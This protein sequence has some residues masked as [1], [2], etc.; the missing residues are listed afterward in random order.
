MK[1]FTPGPWK[2]STSAVYDQVNA[3]D[4]SLI[5]FAAMK[6]N[7]KANARLI[8]AAPELFE[9]LERAVEIIQNEYPVDQHADYGVPSMITALAK[10]K[11][12]DNG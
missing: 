9:A 7:S 12:E 5:C 1:T 3:A 8:A 2:V 6:E 11:G 4:E 10:A